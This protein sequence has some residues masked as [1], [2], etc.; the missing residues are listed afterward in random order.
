MRLLYTQGLLNQSQ[1][2]T[3]NAGYKAIHTG[4]TISLSRLSNSYLAP[5]AVSQFAQSQHGTTN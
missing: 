3:A 4:Y 2:A 1:H 5:V